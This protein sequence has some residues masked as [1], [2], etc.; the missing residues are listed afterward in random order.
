MRIAELCDDYFGLEH[1]AMVNDMQM[2]NDKH[3]LHCT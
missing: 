1:V 2:L 3:T